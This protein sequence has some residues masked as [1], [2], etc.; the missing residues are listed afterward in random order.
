M[1]III[2]I[3]PP[4]ASTSMPFLPVVL[5]KNLKSPYVALDI[6]FAKISLVALDN[7]TLKMGVV[8]WCDGAG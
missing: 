6:K 8:G 3:P 7:I 4:V 5:K 2:I 1:I